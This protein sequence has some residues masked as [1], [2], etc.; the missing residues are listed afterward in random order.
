MVISAQN[1]EA[2]QDA[3]HDATGK[4]ESLE[5]K[6]E[7]SGCGTD[8]ATDEDTAWEKD[9][10]N[11]DEDLFN[12][13]GY[14]HLPKRSPKILSLYAAAWSKKLKA[15]GKLQAKYFKSLGTVDGALAK[16]L[17]K[18]PIVG[19]KKRSPQI[20]PEGKHFGRKKRSAKVLS[21]YSAAW[22]KK[23]KLSGQPLYALF[24]AMLAKKLF[25]VPIVGKKKRSP[26]VLSAYAAYWWKLWKASAL[27][28]K[29]F[30]PASKYFK[31]MGTVDGTLAKLLL[32]VPIVGR[33][34]RSP[35]VLSA[36]AATWWKIWKAYAVLAKPA[37][38]PASKLFKFMGTVDLTIAKLLLKVPIV[39]RN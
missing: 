20:L 18:V 36:N 4:I 13:S 23:L 28:A 24:D 11:F 8:C 6:P 17:L 1:L 2:E 15:T 19:R 27:L 31:F 16:L 14:R 34:K 5:K 38:K 35:K 22:S 32:K 25:K 29:P 12:S 30:P 7:G 10:F 21:L 9:N 33:K 26:K 39:G 3:I 37:S